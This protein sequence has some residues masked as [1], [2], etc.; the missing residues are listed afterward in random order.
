MSPDAIVIVVCV[1]LVW[2]TWWVSNRSITYVVDDYFFREMI[3][4][5]KDFK[6]ATIT[7]YYSHSYFVS[8]RF[9]RDVFILK[10][11]DF[12]RIS[13]A[14][15]QEVAEGICW[16]LKIPKD[17]MRIEVVSCDKV[18]ISLKEAESARKDI[19]D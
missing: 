12:Q 18:K 1:G 6:H 5:R 7:P 15:V 8:A 16:D 2:L 9:G 10:S 3:K 13:G 19:L 4:N 14:K 17:S 11:R